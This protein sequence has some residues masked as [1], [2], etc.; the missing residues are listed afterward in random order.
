MIYSS[1][2]LDINTNNDFE[3][4]E[5]LFSKKNSEAS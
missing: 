5:F 2:I 1:A 3:F 4:A